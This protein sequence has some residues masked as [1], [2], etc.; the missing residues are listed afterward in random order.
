MT[1]TLDLELELWHCI[2]AGVFGWFLMYFVTCWIQSKLNSTANR[3]DDWWY[4]VNLLLWPIV[5][6]VLFL[7]AMH[8]LATYMFDKEYSE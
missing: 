8:R 1:L 2:V 7:M 6:I 5:A 3:N 4:G